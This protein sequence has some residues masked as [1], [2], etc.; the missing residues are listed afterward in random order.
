M[1]SVNLVIQGY[2]FNCYSLNYE[3]KGLIVFLITN[4][5]SIS[6]LKGLYD[7]VLMC[8]PNSVLATH[9]VDFFRENETDSQS[10]KNMDEVIQTTIQ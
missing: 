10:F 9:F 3:F 4:F 7:A 1:N 2:V 8:R 5:H 6:L